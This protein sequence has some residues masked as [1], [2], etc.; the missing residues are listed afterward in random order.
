MRNYFKSH[1]SKNSEQGRSLLTEALNGNVVQEGMKSPSELNNGFN[2]KLWVRTEDSI[3]TDEY[4]KRNSL[5]RSK[6]S[7]LKRP[8]AC[9][10]IKS[11]LRLLSERAQNETVHLDIIVTTETFFLNCGVIGIR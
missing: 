6:M 1:V 9:S 10:T 4:Y 3:K 5:L 11:D 8:M 2:W 7:I